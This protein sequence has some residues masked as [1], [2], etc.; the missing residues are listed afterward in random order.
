MSTPSQSSP[1]SKNLTDSVNIGLQI[2]V[3][4]HDSTQSSAVAQICSGRIAANPGDPCDLAIFVIDPAQ[5]IDPET[6]AHWSALDE[7]MVP[8][9][10]VVVGL[11]NTEADFDDAV[12]LANRVFEQT[13]TPYLVLHDDGGVA[14]ALISLDDMK[15]L[16]YATFPPTIDES[17]SEHQ[18]L[19]S[20]FRNEFLA[21]M[22]VMGPDA[23]TAGMQFPAIPL[24]IEK[25]IGEDILLKY[26]SEVKT[27]KI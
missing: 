4:G 8:R 16:N 19:V 2:H 3:F 6:I 24:W 18:T 11:E 26:I 12:L 14:C 17:E 5:G 15:I 7:S 13:I 1:P 20:E 25:R 10:I 22:D 9:I 23:F 21:A 27:T